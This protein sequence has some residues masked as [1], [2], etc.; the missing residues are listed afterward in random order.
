MIS[1]GAPVGEFSAIAINGQAVA[2]RANAFN[3]CSVDTFLSSGSSVGFS[4]YGNTVWSYH[5]GIQLYKNP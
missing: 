3:S 1:S 2:A 5:I 4:E